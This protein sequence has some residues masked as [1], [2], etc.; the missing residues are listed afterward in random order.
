MGLRILGL[1]LGREQSSF[2]LGQSV[3]VLSGCNGTII[4]NQSKRK[5]KV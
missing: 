2:L 1:G 5:N 3:K 4:Q